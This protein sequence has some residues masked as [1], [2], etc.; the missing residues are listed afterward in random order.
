MIDTSIY[1]N[2]S[3]YEYS[4]LEVVNSSVYRIKLNM[5]GNYSQYDFNIIENAAN[6]WSNIITSQILP[7]SDYDLT[8]NINFQQMASNVLGSA[9]PTYYTIKNGNYIPIEG[10]MT[11]NTLNWNMQKNDIKV[12]GNNEA[13]YT[14]LHEMGHVLGIG[15]MWNLNNLVSSDMLWY[16]GTNALREYKNYNNNQTLIAIPI[17]DNGGGGTAYGHPEEGDSKQSHRYNDG[18]LHPGLDSELM[19][20]YAEG[21]SEPDPL[22]KITIGFLEDI[23]FDV[24]YNRS[25]EYTI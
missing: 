20:G 3:G 12:N 17:E 1:N 7:E 8:I 21:T 13:F 22:S 2:G 14:V 4:N 25:D 16:N 10:E 19:T 18:K 24:D 5:N 15:T 6:T 23:G 11:F 9:G